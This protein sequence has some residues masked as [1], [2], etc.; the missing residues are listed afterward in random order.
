[1]KEQ[2]QSKVFKAKLASAN[3]R[4]VAV[5]AAV[6]PVAAFLGGVRLSNHNETLVRV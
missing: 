2:S 5:S 1:M 6:V 3:V 4:L